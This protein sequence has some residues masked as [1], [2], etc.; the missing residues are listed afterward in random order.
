[1]A[2]EQSPHPRFGLLDRIGKGGM[3][4]AFRA[5]D[6]LTGQVVALKQVRLPLPTVPALMLRGDAELAPTRAAPAAGSEESP[7]H[8][9]TQAGLPL[10]EA[11]EPSSEMQALCVRLRQEFR[12][13]AGGSIAEPGRPR[14]PVHQVSRIGRRDHRSRLQRQAR[15]RD[16]S[17]Q[18]AHGLSLE[19][20]GPPRLAGLRVAAHPSHRLRLRCPRPCPAARQGQHQRS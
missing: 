14:L 20:S 8:A 6:R 1:M 11:A 9:A 5:Q 2:S 7:A 17:F 13:L 10:A 3:G 16:G 15:R 4:E 18:P 12:T 19:P